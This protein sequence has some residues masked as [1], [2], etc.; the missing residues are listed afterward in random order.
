MG[1][2]PAEEQNLLQTPQPAADQRVVIN[3]G[4]RRFET[5]D[6]TLQ[7]LPRSL[8]AD[9]QRRAAHLDVS[10][11]ELFFDRNSTSFEA[12]LNIFQCGCETAQRPASVPPQLFLD[13]LDFYGV[14]GYLAHLLGSGTA[15][16]PLVSA[17]W[18]GQVWAALEPS[19][20]RLPVLPVLSALLTLVA[21]LAWAVTTVRHLQSHAS[22]SLTV[23]QVCT[24]LLLLE[25]VTRA[26]TCPRLLSLLA[27]PMTW[28]DLLATLV[29]LVGSGLSGS[30]AGS[31]LMQLAR[32]AWPLRLWRF[33]RHTRPAVTLKR[34][35]AAS[36]P[37]LGVCLLVWVIG[38]LFF[39][40]I[41]FWAEHGTTMT[42]QS[43]PE[44]MYFTVITMTTV[45]Y[46]DITPVTAAGKVSVSS[47]AYFSSVMPILPIAVFITKFAQISAMTDA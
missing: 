44:A 15:P 39:T 18:R 17:G 1:K 24:A 31:T 16:K 11:G 32:L 40:F 28:I 46:G 23:Q 7:R 21:M 2:L 8:L 5:L 35:L 42:I 45:G 38:A 22:D 4:G 3:V 10:R 14:S 25:L 20:C 19:L 36:G 6:S 13:D 27:D 34:A 37:G 41:V 12:V 43:L 9:R 33:G 26:V 47:C 29:F 30:L